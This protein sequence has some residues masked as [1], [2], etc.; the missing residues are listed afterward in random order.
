M[1][2]LLQAPGLF[3][4]L[5]MALGLKETVIC[6]AIC[7]MVQ[8]VIGLPFLATYPLEYLEKSFEFS[9]VFVYQW[10]VNLKFLPESIFLCKELSLFLLLAT[11]FGETMAD[12]PLAVVTY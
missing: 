3:I 7:A 2:V 8:V 5:L 6:L 11:A 1:N 12:C 10:T 9:R 4:L